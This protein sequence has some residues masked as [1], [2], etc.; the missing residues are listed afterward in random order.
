M[1]AL[2]IHAVRL[3]P[4]EHAKLADLLSRARVK[5]GLPTLSYAG[6]MR[7]SLPLL[8]REFPPVEGEKNSRSK[9]K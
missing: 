3:L 6:L 9:S 2:K 5:T 8:E 7:L 4:E 1:S